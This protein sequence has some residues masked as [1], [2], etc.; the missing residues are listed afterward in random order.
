[1]ADNSNSH[2]GVAKIME[3]ESVVSVIIHYQDGGLVFSRSV[4]TG[5]QFT[6]GGGA[7]KIEKA[8]F[9]AGSPRCR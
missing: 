3:D 2:E 6:L 7:P 9:P 8:C 4:E 5:A 1:M